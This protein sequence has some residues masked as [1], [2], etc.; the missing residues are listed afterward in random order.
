MIEPEGSISYIIELLSDPEDARY[1]L[2]PEIAAIKKT[3]QKCLENAEQISQKFRYWYL[4][5]MHL[6]TTSLSKRGDI[7]KEKETTSLKQE[8]EKNKGDAFDKKQQALE[9]RIQLLKEALDDIQH[10]VEKKEDEVQW[11]RHAP[12][13]PEPSILEDIELVRRVIPQ[14][15]A[16]TIS[17][18][19]MPP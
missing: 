7:V 14:A 12:A 19:H 5:I 1:N 13:Q 9:E 10:R 11:L 6:K 17:K 18:I 3:A 2:K 4:V 15:K 8:E 16:P